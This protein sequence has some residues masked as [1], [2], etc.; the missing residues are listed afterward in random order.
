[1]LKSALQSPLKSAL[2]GGINSDISLWTLA[3]T[4][5]F[6]FY[7]MNS[8][9]TDAGSG[10]ISSWNDYLGTTA[11]NIS[12]GTGASRPTLTSDGV[13]FDGAND[14]LFNSN[15]FM[16]NS[17][18]GVTVI[19][20]VSAPPAPIGVSQWLLCEGSSASANPHLVILGKDTVTGQT[21]L[22]TQ[23]IRNDANT[24]VTAYGLN[25]STTTAYDS[26][27]KLL[28]KK[29]NKANN[30]I[31]LRTNG[32]NGNTPI[33]YT[34]SGT[35]TLNRFSI[36]ALVRDTSLV[37]AEFTLKGLA[38]LDASIS[39]ADMLRAEG[40]LAHLYSQTALLPSDH[41]YKTNPPTK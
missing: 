8:G 5:A 37:F 1:M 22:D 13:V 12:Q 30:T 31:S 19:A 24:L 16:L 38:I 40:Y 27:F 36:G 20:I 32:V 7:D 15:P 35:F 21:G 10:K 25:A 4:Q 6:A 18:N 9:I 34:P 23:Q 11:R 28:T 26:T 17:T 33:T 29:L 41:P 39:D 3:D 2:V 14:F